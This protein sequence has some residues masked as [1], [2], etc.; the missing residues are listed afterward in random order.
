MTPEGE[1]QVCTGDHFERLLFTATIVSTMGS[2]SSNEEIDPLVMS[3]PSPPQSLMRFSK[4]EQICRFL[5]GG[6]MPPA[7]GLIPSCWDELL[8]WAEDCTSLTEEVT[9]RTRVIHLLTGKPGTVSSMKRRI[10][11]VPYVSV[12]ETDAALNKLASST[13]MERAR[14]YQESVDPAFVHPCNLAVL[15]FP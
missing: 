3:V 14:F 12:H 9:Q 2:I 5:L 7:P 6:P 13:Y 11:F 15:C 1:H 8:D 10:R 4:L